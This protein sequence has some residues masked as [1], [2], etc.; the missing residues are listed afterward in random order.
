[1]A[2]DTARDSLLD[3]KC[4]TVFPKT[5]TIIMLKHCKTDITLHMAVFNRVSKVATSG[6]HYSLLLLSNWFSGLHGTCTFYTM[7][8]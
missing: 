5:V 1:M 2:T 7:L 3:G 8:K 6:K 4:K